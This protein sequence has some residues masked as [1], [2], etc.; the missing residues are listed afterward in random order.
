VIN[1]GKGAL[2]GPPYNLGGGFGGIDAI[3][4]DGGQSAPEAQGKSKRDLLWE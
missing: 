4:F 1:A 3:G 2:F